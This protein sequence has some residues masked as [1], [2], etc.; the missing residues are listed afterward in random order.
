MNIDKLDWLINIKKNL[1]KNDG[2][3]LYDIIFE[4]LKNNKM[5][6]PAFLRMASEGHGFSPSEGNGYALDQDWDIPDEFD[7]VSF[8]FGDYES[9]TLSPQKFVELMRLITN[10]Y[11]NEYPEN[12]DMI[13]R[14]MKR[15]QERYT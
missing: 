3:D 11:L 15:L 10:G 5:M 9:S 12:E 1:Y 13:E 6:Y 7:E 4:T 8:M 14:S 2:R